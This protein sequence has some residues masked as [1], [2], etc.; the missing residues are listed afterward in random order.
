MSWAVLSS[1]FFASSTTLLQRKLGWLV[2][3]SSLAHILSVIETL[4]C[5]SVIL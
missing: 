4:F 1:S 5:F 3:E 2:E